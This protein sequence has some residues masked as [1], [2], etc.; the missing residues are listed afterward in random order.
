MVFLPQEVILKKR[1]GEPLAS[2]DI[3]R[4]IAGFAQGND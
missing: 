3:A 4:F 1:N 2:E